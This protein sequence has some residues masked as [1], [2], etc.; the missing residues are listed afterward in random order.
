MSSGTLGMKV[1]VRKLNSLLGY[2]VKKPRDP[3]VINF[4]I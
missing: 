3:T 2:S 4:D 1:V